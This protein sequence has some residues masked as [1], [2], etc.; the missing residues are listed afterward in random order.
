MNNERL[1]NMIK[2]FDEKLINFLP[3]STDDAYTLITTKLLRK[4]TYKTQAT[5]PRH[6]D[7]TANEFMPLAETYR[8]TRKH[9]SR[10]GKTNV[11]KK[12]TTKFLCYS[13][14][15]DGDDRGSEPAAL[16]R[17]E[18]RPCLQYIR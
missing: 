10:P 15:V 5:L 7:K 4:Q 3:R 13:Q 12:I 6:F 17:K 1:K 18:I 14:P 8:L 11:K 16:G 9:I 2:Y